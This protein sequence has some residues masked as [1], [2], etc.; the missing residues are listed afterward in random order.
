MLVTSVLELCRL[1]SD[2]AVLDAA[3]NTTALFRAK[4]RHGPN[5]CKIV[6]GKLRICTSL[7][8]GF[9]QYD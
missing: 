8:Q 6:H 4:K 3:M 1:L 2:S 9:E 5:I 7:D